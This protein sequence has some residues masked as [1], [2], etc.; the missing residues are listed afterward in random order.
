VICLLLKLG[1]KRYIPDDG[2]DD[3]MDEG[4]DDDF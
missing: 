2:Y 3:D 1:F 4:S